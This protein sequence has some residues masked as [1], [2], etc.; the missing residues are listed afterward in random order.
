[1]NEATFKLTQLAQMTML[2]E[3]TLH[4]YIK[5]GLLHGEKTPS[6]WQFTPNWHGVFGSGNC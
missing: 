1:M 6:G 2:T 5:C 3:R 4:N